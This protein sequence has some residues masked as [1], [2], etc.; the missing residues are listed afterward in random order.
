MRPTRRT[1]L[2]WAGGVGLNAW[3]PAARAGGQAEEP[4]A[5]SVRAALASAVADSGAPPKLD[6]PTVDAR[7]AHLR[8]LGAITPIGGVAFIGAWALLAYAVYQS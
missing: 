6:F 3:V 2:A 7:L 4:L 5:D 8:W 1:L